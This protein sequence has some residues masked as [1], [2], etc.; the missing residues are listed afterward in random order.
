MSLI[1]PIK[2]KRVNLAQCQNNPIE[3]SDNLQ[4]S[5]NLY[6]DLTVLDP[7]LP[8]YHLIVTNRDDKT[9]LEAKEFFS[10]TILLH[11]E[12]INMLPLG[13]FNRVIITDSN[14]GLNLIASEANIVLQQWTPNCETSRD[15]LLGV[16]F[17]S[18]ELLIL[19][20]KNVQL[21]SYV[22]R[23]NVFNILAEKYNVQ[24][25][26]ENMFVTTQEFRKLKIKY[27]AFS[28]YQGTLALTIVDHNNSLLLFTID[29]KTFATTLL[30]EKHIDVNVL[31]ILW[32]IGY[33]HLI[34]IGLDNSITSYLIKDNFEKLGMIHPATRFK[35]HYNKFVISDDKC[36]LIS[37]FTGKIVV[38]E[39]GD[40]NYEFKLDTYAACNSI[41][42]GI[43]NGVLTLILSFDTG[44]F[45]TIKFD[46]AS[47]D[48]SQVPL[49]KSLVAFINKLLYSYQF[50]SDNEPSKGTSEPMMKLFGINS[51]PNGT[52]AIFYKVISANVI[53]YR[54]MAFLDINIRFLKLSEPIGN[55]YQIYNRTSI[56]KFID[57]CIDDFHNFPTI[58]NDLRL[59]RKDRV[60]KFI[61]NFKDFKQQ[62]LVNNYSFGSSDLHPLSDFETT[63][64]KSFVENS[65]VIQAQYCYILATFIETGLKPVSSEKLIEVDVILKE[66]QDYKKSIEN[67]IIIYLRKLILGFYNDKTVTDEYGKF[68]LITMLKQLRKLNDITEFNI[69]ESAEV[70]IKTKYYSETFQVS[71]NDID[72]DD[73]DSSNRHIVSTLGHGWTQCQL[74]NIP[75]LQMNNK[76]DERAQFR[77][78]IRN[79][80]FG[81]LVNTLLDTIDFCYI[82]GNKIYPLK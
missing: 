1:N 4:L 39:I 30:F 11:S 70:T 54:S 17:N 71:V 62:Y 67:S 64:K 57:N 34:V 14:E 52:L 15:N 10:E 75:L 37:A 5:L 32:S 31:K 69:S 60:N 23:I 3:W 47:K 79:D 80:E 9:V 41:V 25:D 74:T 77:Y 18:G 21:L 43:T 61:E 26:S 8:D 68:S 27:F 78:V 53:D 49:D 55:E 76:T 6:T 22:V 12:S 56:A 35:N 20:R 58:S 7:K 40:T 50:Q 42:S 46:I 24:C 73:D 19:G 51:L 81:E 38:S 44:K 28:K 2:V 33:E 66:I 72:D 48:F 59:L 45:K 36:Y 82:T 13:R 63:L 16:L 29:E 65:D